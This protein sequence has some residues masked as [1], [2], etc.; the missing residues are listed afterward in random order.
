MFKIFTKYRIMA[1][2]GIAAIFIITVLYYKNQ[3]NKAFI[4]LGKK[5]IELNDMTNQRDSLILINEANLKSLEINNIAKS[6]NKSISES[7]SKKNKATKD[8]SITD[9]NAIKSEGIKNE[10]PENCL[11]QHIPDSIR[12]LLNDQGKDSN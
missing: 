12:S 2:I 3:A 8:K 7:V 6:V 1:S 4:D 11:N 5:E 9:I 10:D